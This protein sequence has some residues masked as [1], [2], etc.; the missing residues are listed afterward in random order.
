VELAENLQG[1]LNE[2]KILVLG[3]GEIG[4][5]VAK[6]MAR[7]CLNP[8]FVANRTYE[9]ASRLA[10]ELG[11]KAVMFDKLG[12]VL[13]DA[14]V[15]FCCTSAPHYLL[16]KEL[17]SWLLAGRQNQNDLLVIDISNPR[18]VEEAINELPNVKLYD[19]DDLTSITERNKHERQK[20]MQEASKILDEEIVSLERAIKADSVDG[21]VSD[22]LT[23]VEENRRRELAKA[24][25]MMK[26]LDEHQRKIVSDLT[27]ILLKQMFLPVVENFRRAAA[28]DE[29]EHIEIAARLFEIKQ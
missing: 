7:R 18:N 22:L 2:K 16:T 15:V 23:Q 3:A 12:E 6:A 10:G 20:S 17:V 19:I 26:E 11:G 5:L 9:R 13:V 1:S 27:S 28:N 4:T 25:S 29:T 24:L 8:I 21:I 14:D